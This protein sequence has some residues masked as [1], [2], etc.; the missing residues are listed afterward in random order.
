M[1]QIYIFAFAILL[2]A[3]V[4]A[5]TAST[6]GNNINKTVSNVN[7]G[8][9]GEFAGNLVYKLNPGESHVEYWTLI[10]K[11]NYPISFQVTPPAYASVNDTS[12]IIHFSALN[13]T[14][15]AGSN[16]TITVNVT[17]PGEGAYFL[18][19]GPK[20]YSGYALA[21][22]K[23]A[24]SSAGGASIALGTA[25]I[26][27]VTITP[28]DIILPIIIVIILIVVAVLAIYLLRK[29]TQNNRKVQKARKRRK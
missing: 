28:S 7:Q 6:S 16:F 5:A 22:S 4:L 27:Q 25:K 29:R 11:F 13:G 26:I 24:A 20:T 21:A 14:I 3:N 1:K 12:P 2:S 17:A 23:P 9:F 8:G 19:T 18:S 15:P 10:N